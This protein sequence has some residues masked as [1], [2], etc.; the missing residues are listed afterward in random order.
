M[1]ALVCAAALAAGLATA[2]A[3]N[4]YSLNVV[5]YYNIPVAAGQ[6]VMIA[7]Q[8]NTTNNTLGA[9]IPDGPAFANFYKYAGGFTAYT[10]DDLDLEWTP[11]GNATLNPGEGAFYVSPV[12][13][14]LT[15]VGEVLQ[16]NLQNTLPVGVQVMRSSMVPQAGLITTDLGLPAEAFDNIYTYSG[17]FSVYTFDDLD[18]EWTPNEPTVGVGQAFFY[19]K[20]AGNVSSTWTRNFTVQ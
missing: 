5:G 8:L 14:T 13:T 19:I 4:V 2:A 7:N 9:L 1:K 3:Q 11:D 15:F 17:G 12:A 20:A 18:L 6:M 16:G 10:F